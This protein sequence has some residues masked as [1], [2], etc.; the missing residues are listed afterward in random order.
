MNNNFDNMNL[1]NANLYDYVM[2]RNQYQNTNDDIND[3]KNKNVQTY[4]EPDLKKNKKSSMFTTFN[5]FVGLLIIFIVLALYYYYFNN[6]TN[7]IDNYNNY[8]N[9]SSLNTYYLKR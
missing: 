1:D 5:I 8:N 3:L 4:S 2:D 9:E 7:K 6:N